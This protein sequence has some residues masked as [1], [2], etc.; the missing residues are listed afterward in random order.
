METLFAAPVILKIFVSLAIIL[1][2]SHYLKSLTPAVVAATAVLAFWSGHSPLASWQIAADRIFSPQQAILYG[3][4]FLVISLSAQMKACGNMTAMVRSLGSRLSSRASMAILP[5]IIGLLPMPGGAVFSA[6]LVDGVKGSEKLPGV[7]KTRI[8]YWFRHMW[9]FWWPLYPGVLLA[10]DLSGLPVGK[11]IF[12]MSPLTLV[13]IL[14][15]YLFLLRRISPGEVHRRQPSP[16]F[17]K[18]VLPIFIVM[19]AFALVGILIPSVGKISKYLPMGIGLILAMGVLQGLHPLK[20]KAWKTI[21]FSPKTMGL[22][23]LIVAV[24][25]Y[26]AFIEA[27]LPEGGTMMEVMNRE[28]FAWGIPVGFFAVLLPFFCG[29]VMGVSVGTV[30]A[31][32]PIVLSLIGPNPSETA[33]IGVVMVAY[34]AGLGGQILSPVHVCLVV[35]NR[36]FK[37]GIIDSLRGLILPTAATLGGALLLS[38]LVERLF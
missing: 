13:Y 12:F 16:G 23:L 8:N 33:T 1:L 34:A 14:G 10:I 22:V 35:T 20:G 27:P 19:A 6:P 38:R 26:G 4:I 24:R 28:L 3:V 7:A 32:F 15:G 17:F 11:Y 21:L 18:A 36:Y 29:F 5:A 2:G 30:G 25:T 9:E 31:C 37:S